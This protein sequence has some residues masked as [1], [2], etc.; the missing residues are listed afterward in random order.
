[1]KKI[2]L[3]ILVSLFPSI[4]FSQIKVLDNEK[5]ITVGKVGGGATSP[6]IASLQFSKGSDDIDTYTLL[7]NN[8]RYTTIE[9][10]N[11][12]VFTATKVELENLYVILKN[13]LLDDSGN[14]KQIELG[15]ELVIVKTIKNFGVKSLQITTSDEGSTGFFFLS[16]KQ[17]DKLFGK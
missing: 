9:D 11:S 2:F 6:F 3:I 16:S 17:L 8:L 5:P 12:I 10:I 1:M 13:C 14:E 4:L 7:Y 15:K